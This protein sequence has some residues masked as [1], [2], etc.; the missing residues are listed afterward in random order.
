[1]AYTKCEDEDGKMYIL[2]TPDGKPICLETATAAATTTTSTCQQQQQQQ[3]KH[4]TSNNSNSKKSSSSNILSDNSNDEPDISEIQ[5]Q[6][7]KSPDEQEQ[8][9]QSS[10]QTSNSPPL[11]LFFSPVQD[12]NSPDELSS[13]PVPDL[14][15]LALEAQIPRS[16]TA[17]SQS[18]AAGLKSSRGRGRV[19]RGGF[20]TVG[21]DSG[22]DDD[23]GEYSGDDDDD[24]GRGG[25]EEWRRLGFV[26]AG[27]S[28]RGRL[29]FLG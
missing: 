29:S 18:L 16:D 4:L 26:E 2:D 7:I 21:E 22:D 12:F 9:H 6:M 17:A 8:Q 13:A 20:A 24:N 5:H 15:L 27:C 23:D 28:S 11:L 3:Q 14:A 25:D 1:M 10:K 19:E